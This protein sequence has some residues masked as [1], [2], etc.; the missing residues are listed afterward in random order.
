MVLTYTQNSA[1]TPFLASRLRA[2]SNPLKMWKDLYLRFKK[3]GN[4]G[5]EFSCE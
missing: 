2:D 5:F 4:F 3:L 1:N